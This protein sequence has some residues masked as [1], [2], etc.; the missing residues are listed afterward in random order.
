MFFPSLVFFS[1]EHLPQSSSSVS[2]SRSS[3]TSI[4]L[5]NLSSCP[6]YVPIFLPSY[7]LRLLPDATM[8]FYRHLYPLDGKYQPITV[9]WIP[10]LARLLH[11][12]PSGNHNLSNIRASQATG[13]LR[14]TLRGHKGTP[15]SR[16]VNHDTVAL[17]EEAEAQVDVQVAHSREETPIPQSWVPALQH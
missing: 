11:E 13:W 4:L 17:S 15:V 12:L 5:F 16:C 2:Y 14:T 7:C 9:L 3:P 6:T 1:Q 10:R 8:H